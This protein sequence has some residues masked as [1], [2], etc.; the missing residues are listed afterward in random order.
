VLKYT[1]EQVR[2]MTV[3]EFN[4]ALEGYAEGKGIKTGDKL[5]SRNDFLDMVGK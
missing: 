4:L 3:V 1:P 5:T 2:S